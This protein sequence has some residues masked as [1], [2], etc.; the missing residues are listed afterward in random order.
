MTAVPW[1]D[2]AAG[3]LGRLERQHQELVERAGRLF[4]LAD[5]GKG[6]ASATREALVYFDSYARF[7]FAQEELLMRQLGFP[8]THAHSQEHA[9]AVRRLKAIQGCLEHQ[10]DEGTTAREMIAFLK[11]W[12]ENHI[13]HLDRAFGEYA[14]AVMLSTA[15]PPRGPALRTTTSADC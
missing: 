4:G 15:A 12:I 13:G 8:G 9:A 3:A 11:E 5:G 2:A 1:N 6:G 10:V 7:H 14:S